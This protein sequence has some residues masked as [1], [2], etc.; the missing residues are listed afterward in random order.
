MRIRFRKKGVAMSAGS[1]VFLIVMLLACAVTAGVL[2][3]T[4]ENFRAKATT[5]HRDLREE[6]GTNI[7]VVRLFGTG[8]ADGYI[9]NLSVIIRLDGGSDSI[10]FSNVVLSFSLINAT[11]SLSYGA[12][13][14][15][16]NFRM[17]YLVNGTEHI[18]GYMVRG[19]MVQLDFVPPRKIT[20]DEVIKITIIPKLTS[21]AKIQTRTPPVIYRDRVDIFP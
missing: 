16:N 13:P 21:P 12:L 3:I 19:D 5:T 1:M 9:D 17:N 20:G 10:Q 6:I 7:Q 11:S 18:D 2:I 15:T 4:T 8:G 14:S